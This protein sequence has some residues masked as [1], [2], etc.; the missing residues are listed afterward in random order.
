VTLVM[1]FF[2]VR[3][4][5]WLGNPG[6]EGD[7]TYNQWYPTWSP[8][9]ILDEAL[10]RTDDTNPYIYL[11]DGGHFENL[12]VY[13][14][15]LRRCR[16]IVACDG[17]Q[18]ADFTFEDLGNLVRKARVDLGIPIEFVGKSSLFDCNGKTKRPKD[19]RARFA[20]AR[21]RYSAI[22]KNKKDGLLVYIKPVVYGKE[23][24]RDV[25]QYWRSSPDF[26]HETT[27]DQFFSESQFESYRALGLFTIRGMIESDGDEESDDTELSMDDFIERFAPKLP[28]WWKGADGALPP[29]EPPAKKPRKSPK[30]N[31]QNAG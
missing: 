23:E 13:E 27:V 21:I 15:I 7:G 9:P 12:A 10:G 31:P 19:K 24:P 25:V 29:S 22:D 16:V 5:W 30:Q 17:G 28:R 8:K 2:N 11:S 1:T 14:M 6:K 18:D 26:P 3:L 4:G 20:V